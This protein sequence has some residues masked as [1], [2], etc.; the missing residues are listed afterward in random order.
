MESEGECVFTL[1]V[2][3]YA[4]WELRRDDIGTESAFQHHRR[5]VDKIRIRS[6]AIW[7]PCE[8]RF[9]I[10]MSIAIVITYLRRTKVGTVCSDLGGL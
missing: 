5:S 6:L 1:C 8:A 9:L 2:A 7:L 10:C 4:G 3:L